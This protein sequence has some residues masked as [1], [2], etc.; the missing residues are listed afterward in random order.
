MTSDSLAF[1]IFEKIDDDFT[2]NNASYY[3]AEFVTPEDHGTSHVSIV[4]SSGD[5]ISV[6]TTINYM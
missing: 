3:G 2:V 5:A 1:E 6:T 4:G